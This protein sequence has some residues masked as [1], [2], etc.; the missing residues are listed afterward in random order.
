MAGM[1]FF[2]DLIGVVIE[3]EIYLLLGMSVWCIYSMDHLMDSRSMKESNLAF[4]RHI[5][6]Q[7]YFKTILS[8]V[9]L[10]ALVGFVVLMFLEKLWFLIKPGFVLST[11]IVVWFAVLYKSGQK[12]AWL[13]EVSTAMVYVV[14]IALAPALTKGIAELGPYFWLFATLYFFTALLNLF[15][16]S[17]IDAEG[18]KSEG[19]GSILTV[20]SKSLLGK[21]I[22][23]MGLSLFLLLIIQLVI[24]PSY[25][26]LHAGI[27][28]LICGLHLL[29][30]F[31][32]GQKKRL[33]AKNWKPL[34]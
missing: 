18:D 13:K 4:P 26:S 12:A 15:I 32:K 19:F 16:L 30:F 7:K 2:S 8:G 14:G 29:Y 21:I 1:L 3:W 25:F 22:F 27:L 5:F 9:L 31:S 11:L 17:Y 6:H 10:L 23:W 24:L 20:I 34:L 28:L 33:S